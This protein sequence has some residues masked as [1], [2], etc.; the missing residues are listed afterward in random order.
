MKPKLQ[1]KNSYYEVS[2]AATVL[3]A[4]KNLIEKAFSHEYIR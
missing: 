1:N 4:K 3:R 2:N